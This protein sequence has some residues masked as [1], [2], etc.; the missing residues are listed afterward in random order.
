MRRRE[1]E[2]DADA[3]AARHAPLTPE[4]EAAASRGLDRARAA[5]AREARISKVLRA[6]VERLEQALDVALDLRRAH[7]PRPIVAPTSARAA[8]V[9]CAVFGASD[10]HVEKVIRP[11]HVNGQNEYNP[12][13]ARRRARAF[14][15]GCLWLLDTHR[16]GAR[17]DEAVLALLGDMIEGWIHEEFQSGNA[18]SPPEATLFAQELLGDVIS[19]FLARA[20]LRRLRVVCSR[21]NHSRL[22]KRTYINAAARLSYEWL[23]FRALAARFAK[24]PRV[25]FVIED[26]YHTYLDVFGKV[27]RFHHGDAVTYQGGVGGLTIPM[28]KKIQKWDQ[29]RPAYLDVVGHFHQLMHGGRFIVNG[30]LCGF[31]DY[32]NWIAASPEPPQQVF[33]LMRPGR[34]LSAFAPV[35][36][37]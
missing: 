14:V 21:G 6:E 27:L 20:R 7:P 18:M 15:E 9:A 37:T 23:M 31:D 8:K 22:T 25:E 12:D 4:Q 33:F 26:G 17:I 10:W 36:V 30:S 29:A 32:A 1:A 2:R 24:D 34:G 3:F 35:F 28:L 11:S 13:V 5:A 19:T 16:R